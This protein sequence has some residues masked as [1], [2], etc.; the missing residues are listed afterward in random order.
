MT[1]GQALAHLAPAHLLTCGERRKDMNLI[2]PDLGKIL[3]FVGGTLLG[4]KLLAKLRG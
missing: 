1:H 4:G 2:M 3:W